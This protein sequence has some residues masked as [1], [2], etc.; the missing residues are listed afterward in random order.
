MEFG[1]DFDA[2][3]ARF[4][5]D[6][7]TK[8][9]VAVS[10]GSD[11]VALLLLARDWARKS[12]RT[13]CVFTVDHGLRAA[14]RQEA[15]WVAD[16]C[17]RLHLEHRTLVWNDPKPTQNAARQARYILLSD[18]TADC[19]SEAL[20]V[21]HTQDD[22]L[23][24]ALI[25]RRRGVRDA[26]AAGP[27]L[28]SPM[29]V[30]PQGRG[31]TLLRPLI[32]QRRARLREFLTRRGQ[33]WLEDPSNQNPEF[34]RIAIRQGLA[35]HPGLNALAVQKTAR[36]QEER[37]AQEQGLGTQLNQCRVHKD[38]LIEAPEEAMSDQLLGVLVR[39]ASGSDRTPRG[40]AIRRL[41]MTAMVQGERQTLGGAWVQK[42]QSGYKFGRDPG[43]TFKRDCSGVFDGRFKGASFAQLPN[44][45]DQ[46]FLVRHASPPGTHWR[47]IISERLA[48]LARC[49]QT[50]RLNPVQT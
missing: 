14:A 25:R 44:P 35:R 12:G 42:G 40:R 43:A 50:P 11:S 5:P 6:P 8:L 34:E 4:S 36:L 16:L 24:T 32:F 10:G 48:H 37:M 7:K 20:L 46:A 1:P 3:I 33:D 45:E 47:E 29:P 13:L 2:L 41:N 17:G 38:G 18:A 31:Q 9:A 21:G 23:E 28:A 19:G 30:W 26:R 49:Y 22:V 15:E 39:C 27:A